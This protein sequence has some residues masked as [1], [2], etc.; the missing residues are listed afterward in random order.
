MKLKLCCLALLLSCVQMFALDK[1]DNLSSFAKIYG[2][3]RYYSPNPY[4]QA[5]DETDWFKVAYRY[6]R[7]YRESDCDES[8]L[9]DFLNVFA[10]NATL[11]AEPDSV[12][13]REEAEDKK[14]DRLL[15]V[16]FYDFVYG[17]VGIAV[18]GFTVTLALKV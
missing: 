11:T 8:V 2:I 12:Y 6:V 13:S 14:A 10:P 18:A 4:T 1:I 16:G 3:V 15:P 5:W 17:D 7:S 9:Y